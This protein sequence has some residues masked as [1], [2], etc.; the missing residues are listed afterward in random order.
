M[1]D[2]QFDR[3]LKS[4]VSDDEE[5]DLLANFIAGRLGIQYYIDCSIDS[6]I[7]AMTKF[8]FETLLKLAKGNNN[9]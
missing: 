9:D 7:C 6:F 2:E 4:M 3:V 8:E 1:D 5:Y